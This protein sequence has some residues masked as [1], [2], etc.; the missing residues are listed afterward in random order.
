[1]NHTK[2]IEATS[3]Q[4]L[5][6]T[7]Q[8]LRFLASVNPRAA[9]NHSLAN[10]LIRVLQKQSLYALNAQRCY[11]TDHLTFVKLISHGNGDKTA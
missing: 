1:M 6:N 7:A 9:K 11:L 4:D 5:M 8:F 2:T 3:L 10:H